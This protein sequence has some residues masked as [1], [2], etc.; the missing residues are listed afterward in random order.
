[1]SST[2]VGKQVAWIAYFCVVVVVYFSLPGPRQGID[3]SGV[4][5][6]AF[7]VIARLPI[8]ESGSAVSPS[9]CS[10]IGKAHSW[11]LECPFRSSLDRH[12]IKSL[13]A[14]DGWEASESTTTEL[15]FKKDQHSLVIRSPKDGALSTVVLRGKW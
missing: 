11:S 7:H 5:G 12:A 6:K 2:P 10:Y 14:G 3:E 9:K 8:V 13:L 1:M 4:A 15:L